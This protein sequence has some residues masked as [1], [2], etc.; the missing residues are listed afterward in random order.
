M[1][2]EIQRIAWSCLP[3][4]FK[5]EVKYYYQHTD[6]G[7]YAEDMLESIFGKHNLTSDA[8]GEAD[9]MLCVKRKWVQEMYKNNCD[10]IRRENISSSDK[11]C[12]EYANEVLKTLFGSKCLPDDVAT[13]E[14]N[15]E[16]LEPNIESLEP[17]PAE[18]KFKAGDKVECLRNRHIYVIRHLDF[19]DGI[20]WYNYGNP[21][22]WIKESDLEPYTEPEENVNLSQ[23]M[24]NCD[25]QFDSILKDS[26]SK[27]RRLNI[28]A[29]FMSAMMSNPSVFH[30]RLNSEE[31]DFIIYGSLEFADTLIAE[32]LKGGRNGED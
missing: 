11:D 20:W 17:K 10:A 24:S 1:D 3:K 9:E 8:E 31:E 32:A 15:I 5:E 4:E 2:K 18:P 16:S 30:S 21:A 13:S 12:Y 14:P 27:E 26:F 23:P 29:Q 19:D 28:A 22:I 7:T 25:K 6:C